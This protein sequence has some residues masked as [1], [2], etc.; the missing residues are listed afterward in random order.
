MLRFVLTVLLAI[1]T[2]ALFVH[3]L[4][5]NAPFRAAVLVL[6]VGGG[7]WLYW[8]QGHRDPHRDVLIPVAPSP[9]DGRRPAPL[10]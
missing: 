3:L 1:L 4:T 10:D 8:L 2:L 6:A 9:A 7:L 5:R